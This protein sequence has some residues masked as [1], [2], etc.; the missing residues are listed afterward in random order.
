MTIVICLCTAV[1]AFL[2][3]RIV[4]ELTLTQVTLAGIREWIRR[5]AI[6][7]EER[8]RSK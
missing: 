8:R 5:V 7:E 6:L 2:L 4:Q 3:Y 1:V